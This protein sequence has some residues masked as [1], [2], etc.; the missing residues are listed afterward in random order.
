MSQVLY[1]DYFFA[2]QFSTPF[3]Q[4]NPPTPVPYVP[5]SSLRKRGIN[6]VTCQDAMRPTRENSSLFALTATISATLIIVIS[7]TLIVA[8][9]ARVVT[10]TLTLLV[11]TLPAM[12]RWK[13]C[14]WRYYVADV[15]NAARESFITGVGSISDPISIT[16]SVFTRRERQVV[17]GE[18]GARR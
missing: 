18:R 1:I 3:F 12:A 5:I 4:H 7:V 11:V 16:S 10:E 13:F 17:L 2:H 15:T 9:S 8:I 6:P 14:F